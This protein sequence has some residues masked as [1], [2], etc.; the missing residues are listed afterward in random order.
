MAESR[1]QCCGTSWQCPLCSLAREPERGRAERAQ[2]GHANAK[3][4]AQSCTSDADAVRTA[5]G[6]S[7]CSLPSWALHRDPGPHGRASLAEISQRRTLR[8]GSSI[9][10][11]WTSSIQPPCPPDPGNTWCSS[12]MVPSFSATRRPPA[13]ERVG[14]FLTRCRQSARDAGRT[15]LPTSRGPGSSTP[16][17]TR[18]DACRRCVSRPAQAP[19]LRLEA[20]D[21]LVR[22]ATRR[23]TRAPPSFRRTASTSTSFHRRGP[24]PGTASPSWCGSMAATS[25][26]APTRA[27]STTARALSRTPL[28]AW[29][30]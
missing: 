21:P 29:S 15:P 28:A 24:A 18:P 12:A 2:R 3:L 6:P 11:G 4:K 19:D 7:L 20:P 30:S 16:L 1:E 9:T 14:G 10:I 8:R 22:S 27:R 25:R 23:R 13:S 26:R 17:L 5:C